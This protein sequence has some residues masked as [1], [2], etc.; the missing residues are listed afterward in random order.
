[1]NHVL[2]IILY[3][4]ILVVFVVVLAARQ[5]IIYIQLC[6]YVE[7][8]LLTPTPPQQNVF[9]LIYSP[10]HSLLMILLV[11]GFDG[12][13]AYH[14][15]IGIKVRILFHGRLHSHISIIDIVNTGISTWGD[16]YGTGGGHGLLRGTIL[17]SS[18]TAHVTGHF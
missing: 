16:N 13:P 17:D 9:H 18:A 3:Q 15:V 7:A 4:L 11:I 10:T 12:R 14:H 5:C 1:M 8:L 6:V 2:K